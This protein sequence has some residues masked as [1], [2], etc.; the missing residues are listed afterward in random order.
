MQLLHSCAGTDPAWDSLSQIA[1]SWRSRGPVGSLAPAELAA[2]IAGASNCADQAFQ[3]H[4][5]QPPAA[6]QP[7]PSA[8]LLTALR[9]MP[10]ML[11]R[12]L[13]EAWVR[14]RQQ[15]S[16]EGRE[17]AKARALAQQLAGAP[18]RRAIRE[19]VAMRLPNQSNR[20][21]LV[22]DPL[23]DPVR[24]LPGLHALQLKAL[25]S[26]PSCLISFHSWPTCCAS[27]HCSCQ[28]V[29]SCL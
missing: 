27:L 6:Q 2:I 13:M 21:A 4:P 23:N 11:T 8:T 16:A 3:Q 9:G 5:Q 10:E 26:K 19:L 14:P 17:Q 25:S 22:F 18:L 28:A 20:L 12:G 29:V 24:A 1:T 7:T 15:I